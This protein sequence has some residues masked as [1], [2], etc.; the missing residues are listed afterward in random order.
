MRRPGW[1]ALVLRHGPAWKPL[2]LE[3]A[4]EAAAP[5]AQL[6]ELEWPRA[7]VAKGN[8]LQLSPVPGRVVYGDKKQ[9]VERAERGF[10]FV[11]NSAAQSHLESTLREGLG[12]VLHDNASFL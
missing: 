10:T 5:W 11:P 2:A 7:Q 8:G 6:W 4:Q 12:R 3:E 9:M 1:G